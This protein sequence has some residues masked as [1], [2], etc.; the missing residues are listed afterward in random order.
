MFLII[1]TQFQ[2]FEKYVCPHFKAMLYLVLIGFHFSFPS[3]INH[4]RHFY[5]T[6]A[7]FGAAAHFRQHLLHRSSR[8]SAGGDIV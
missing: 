4:F 1:N 2:L 8:K 7:C 5:I 6:I 3:Q